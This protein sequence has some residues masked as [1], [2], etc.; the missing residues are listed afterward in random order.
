M[1]K[2]CT[3]FNCICFRHSCSGLTRI[4]RPCHFS[5]NTRFKLVA[6]HSSAFRS[7]TRMKCH[8][9]SRNAF[10][11]TQEGP[12]TKHVFNAL[13]KCAMW[14]VLCQ[15]KCI[16]IDTT[17]EMSYW[18]IEKCVRWKITCVRVTGLPP[19]PLILPHPSPSPQHTYIATGKLQRA[20]KLLIQLK[21]NASRYATREALKC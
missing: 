2:K 18:Q 12:K 19:L 4:A 17:T 9:I 21:L 14:S 6:L 3:L 10:S 8:T 5:L 13:D 20:P 7:F 15:R 11:L 1:Y 16:L